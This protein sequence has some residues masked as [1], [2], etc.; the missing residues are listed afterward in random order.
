MRNNMTVNSNPDP[1]STEIQRK[2]RQYR[3]TQLPRPYPDPKQWD[4][5][6]KLALDSNS[7]RHE[8]YRKFKESQKLVDVNYL[9]VRLDIEPV[10]RCNYRCT[11]CQVSD[12]GPTY[13]R[14]GDMSFEEFKNLLSL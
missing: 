8:N 6:L 9:P 4:D 14:A 13:Q 11:M 5:N 7:L 3:R 2:N 10:S 12:W 1:I